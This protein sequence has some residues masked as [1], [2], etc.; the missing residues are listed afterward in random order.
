MDLG[1]I[2]FTRKMSKLMLTVCPLAFLIGLVAG[3]ES[4][5]SA[6]A[7]GNDKLPY[8]LHEVIAPDGV[9]LSVQE[10]GNAEGPAILFIHGYAQSHLNW[11]EQVEDSELTDEFRMITFDLRGHGMSE[12]PEGAPFYRESKRWAGDVEAIIESLELVNPVIVASS[13]GG[14]VVGDYIA[15]HGNEKIGGFMP[16]GAVLMDDPTQWFGPATRLFEPMA[17]AD[18]TTAITATKSFVENLFVTPPSEDVLQLIFGYTMMTPRHVRKA[19]LGR[20]ADFERHW[21]ELTVPVLLSHGVEDQVIKLGMSENA[22]K[23]MGNARTSFMDGI[24]HCP[25]LE[26]P[27][28]FNTELQEFVRN[29]HQK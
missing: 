1:I 9:T 5:T 13:M 17:S 26:A 27:D 12:K 7:D 4:S 29:V 28:R 25:Y 24:G 3:C 2:G 10:W 19:L 22:A 21:R 14:R 6:Y 18:L 20:D 23:L 11:K 8:T 15:H 16:V